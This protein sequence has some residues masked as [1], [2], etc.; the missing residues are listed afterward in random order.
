MQDVSRIKRCTQAYCNVLHG[1]SRVERRV[2]AITSRHGDSISQLLSVDI[3]KQKKSYHIG[4][5]IRE[6]IMVCTYK[7]SYRSIKLLIASGVRSLLRLYKF[8]CKVSRSID[9]TI[10]NENS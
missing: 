1:K 2:N 3:E 9:T 10:W 5:I 6:N 8:Y 7:V 4:E